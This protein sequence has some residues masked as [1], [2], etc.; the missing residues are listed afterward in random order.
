MC[1][2]VCICLRGAHDCGRGEALRLHRRGERR[3]RDRRGRVHWRR[4]QHGRGRAAWHGRG[5]SPAAR[6]WRAAC[7]ARAHIL[8]TDRP[9]QRLR[10]QRQT[11][12]CQARR[13]TWTCVRQHATLLTRVRQH[14][15][16]P[17]VS[18]RLRLRDDR[19]VR[20]AGRRRAGRSPSNIRHK[21]AER[22][23]R[24]HAYTRCLALVGGGP[25]QATS[26]PS[27]PASLGV[28]SARRTR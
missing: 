22:R 8:G 24:A 15:S 27:H 2:C 19:A 7:F 25:H 6:P 28:R 17:T 12:S 5:R 21:N 3:S 18:P 11:T 23:E 1:V 4:V 26:A 14:A 9:R 13:A 20:G 16:G 10:L